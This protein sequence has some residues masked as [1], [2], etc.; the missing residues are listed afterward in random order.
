[1]SAQRILVIADEPLV[2]ETVDRYLRSEGYEIRI[3]KI[4]C[5]ALSVIDRFQ[6]DLIVVGFTPQGMNAA[7]IYRRIRARARILTPIIVLAQ[8][9]DGVDQLLALEIP[10]DDYVVKPFSR[11]QLTVRVKA[12]LRGCERTASANEEDLRF[13]DLRI[14]AHTGY[15]ESPKGRARLTSKE[16]ELLRFLARHPGKVFSKEQLL[17][18]VWVCELPVAVSTV[19]F[20]MQRLR[21]K[22]E[23]DPG[24]PRHLKT[25]YGVGYTFEP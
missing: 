22:V 20:H 12:L 10:R 17:Y 16:F 1:M 14:G 6:P 7:D 25:V 4:D 3:T 18:H 9:G 8:D 19:T 2:A 23:V 5:S 21:S 11:R 15:V 24:R 13:D